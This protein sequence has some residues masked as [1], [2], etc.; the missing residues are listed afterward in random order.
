MNFSV[1]RLLLVQALLATS[2]LALLAFP[3]AEGFG[4]QATG[5]RTGTVYKV[6]NLNDSGT[7]SLILLK[8]RAPLTNPSGF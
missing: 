4:A 2:S 3:G 7:G 8:R 5:G 1:W 6:T